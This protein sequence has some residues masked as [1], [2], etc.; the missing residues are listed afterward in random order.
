[1]PSKKSGS[2]EPYFDAPIVIADPLFEYFQNL[3]KD[4]DL[5]N[6]SAKETE[7]TLPIVRQFGQMQGT[8]LLNASDFC[9]TTGLSRQQLKDLL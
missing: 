4:G 2:H 9:A 1:M 6:V 7:V 5:V 8:R 3:K